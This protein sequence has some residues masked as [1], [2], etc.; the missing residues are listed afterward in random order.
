[1][2]NVSNAVASLWEED[3][4]WLDAKVYNYVNASW[5]E[6][7]NDIKDFS[8]TKGAMSDGEFQFG[9][10]I[11]PSCTITMYDRYTPSESRLVRVDIGID[12][13]GTTSEDGEYT[14]SFSYLTLGSFYLE[15][16]EANEYESILTCTSEVIG[17]LGNKPLGI[18]SNS[19]IAIVNAVASAFGLTINNRLGVDATALAKEVSGKTCRE[20]LSIVAKSFGGSVVEG[21]N[22]TP[23]LTLVSPFVVDAT[24]ILYVNEERLEQDFVS[25]GGITLDSAE[26]T[27]D[28][29]ADNPTTYTFGSEPYKYKGDNEYM[30]STVFAKFQTNV[31]DKG[32]A[33]G[34]VSMLMGDPRIEP[35]DRIALYHLDDDGNRVVSATVPVYYV[36][37]RYDGSLTTTVYAPVPQDYSNLVDSDSKRLSAVIGQING[38]REKVLTYDEQ[39]ETIVTRLDGVDEGMRSKVDSSLVKD[40]VTTGS[41]EWVEDD[42]SLHIV[43]QNAEGNATYETVVGGDGIKFKYNGETVAS[44]DQD[45]LV[46]DKTIVF[47]SMQVGKWKWEVQQNENLTLKWGGN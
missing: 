32:Y 33:S 11:C 38:V 42:N 14:P 10:T 44:V 22:N 2:I 13:G 46:I 25:T 40:D 12:Q 16:L 15:K 36:E 17:R 37:H 26:I 7:T 39:I 3:A 4:R 27:A 8:V 6:V 43:G 35:L 41:M 28:T 19:P 18:K 29:G 24:K 34:E 9:E 20:A 21:Y 23:T 45:Q 47:T 1:M 30:S 5:V 31:K